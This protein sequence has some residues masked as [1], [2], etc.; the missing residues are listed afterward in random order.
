MVAVKELDVLGCKLVPDCTVRP[1]F[2][3]PALSQAAP[4]EGD[5]V[6]VAAKRP[7]KCVA[8]RWKRWRQASRHA[9]A[10]PAFV[11]LRCSAG[12]S[13]RSCS[14]PVGRFTSYERQRR[15]QPC[16]GT[17][18]EA[19]LLNILEC[20][21]RRLLVRMVS[22]GCQH[23]RRYCVPLKAVLHLQ[24]HTGQRAA[25]CAASCSLRGDGRGAQAG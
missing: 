6:V 5:P 14:V 20:H 13:A 21:G 12:G 25:F 8:H 1:H 10:L 24:A 15:L 22:C 17:A 4:A 16:K 11:P 7:S 3:C 2:S 23:R 9:Q 19:H 18:G